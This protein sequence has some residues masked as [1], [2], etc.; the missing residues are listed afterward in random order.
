MR[1]PLAEPGRTVS[2][3]RVLAGC[4]V[5]LS[6]TEEDLGPFWSGGQNWGH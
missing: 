2:E 1:E 5:Q 6:W 3:E 4:R